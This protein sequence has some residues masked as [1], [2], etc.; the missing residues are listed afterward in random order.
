MSV[1]AAQAPRAPVTA[2]TLPPERRV[3]GALVR[4]GLREKRRAPLIWGGC[5]GAMGALFAAMWPSIEGSVG[6]L[7]DA[8]PA[9]LK[10]AFGI[11][12]LDTA[13]AYIDAEL[14]SLIAPFALTFFAVRAVTRPIVGAEERGHLDTILSLPVSRRALVAASFVVAGV[15]LA[16][17]LVVFWALTFLAGIVAGAGIAAAPLAVGLLNVWPLAMAFAGLA[18]AACG[19]L[20]SSAGVTAAAM[21]TLVAMYVIDLLGKLTEVM[22][23]ARPFTAFRYYGSAVQDGIDLSH[24]AGLTLT[25]ILLAVLG[26]VLFERRDV[27]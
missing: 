1:S 26:A 17:T 7:L 20:H 19:V 22:E 21:G 9:G 8:Y 14:L 16:V 2:R 24:A 13:V 15:A 11:V 23:P 3:F 6:E 27:R 18:A 25:G 4:R 10:E 5:F 12:R